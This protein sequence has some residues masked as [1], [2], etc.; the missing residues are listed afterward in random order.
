[1]KCIKYTG[2]ILID[3]FEISGIPHRALHITATVIPQDHLTLPGTL[4]DNLIPHDT[5][6]LKGQGKVLDD[7]VWRILKDVKLIDHIKAHGDLN[8]PI[9]DM[10]LSG[11]QKQ[12]IGIARGMLHHVET[13]SHIV[14]VDEATSSLDE[15]MEIYI[16]DLMVEFFSF[17][18][19]ICIAHRKAAFRGSNF[20]YWLE[21][22]RIAHSLDIDALKA[23]SSH[24]PI[25]YPEFYYN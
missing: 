7:D 23:K 17:A 4:R 18:A 15:E 9:E 20:M 16:H 25:E 22:G 24:E 11:G 12:L 10:A 8:T 5:L 13:G 1:M 14:I 6:M 2:S 3:E 19:Y 21:D